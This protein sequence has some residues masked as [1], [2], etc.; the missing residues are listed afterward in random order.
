LP[1]PFDLSEL[2]ARLSTALR[3]PLLK[4]V[5]NVRYADLELDLDTRGAGRG[6][7]RIS[8]STREFDLVAALLRYPQRVFTRKELL[9]TVWGVDPNVTRNTI[10]TYI[11]YVRA[12][13][14]GPAEA[15][16]IGVNPTFVSPAAN[17]RFRPRVQA[18]NPCRARS[19][20]T[21]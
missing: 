15:R 1:K 10:E 12:K 3:R 8:L 2:V 13:I 21:G 11:S 4:R 19:G 16:L 20:H 17:W 14:D 18:V 9:D 6:E 5:R 7:R